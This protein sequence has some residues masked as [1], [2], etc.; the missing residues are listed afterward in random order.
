MKARMIIFV[1][2]LSLVPFFNAFPQEKTIEGEI[3]ATGKYIDV[4]DH[5]GGKAKFTEYRDLQENGGLF[6]PAGRV[7]PGRD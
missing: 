3:S 5:E 6:A 4:T 2:I 7:S 1:L